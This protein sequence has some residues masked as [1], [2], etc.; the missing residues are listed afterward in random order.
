MIKKDQ[1]AHIANVH[2]ITH[3]L[4]AR[5]LD[6]LTD[7]VHDT[8]KEGKPFLLSGVGKFEASLRKG[9]MGRNPQNGN[10][11]TIPEA[12]VVKFKAS[13]SIKDVLN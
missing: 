3:G 13:Q 2:G 10:P 8:L 6:T 9:R 5:I 12:T 7:M 1:V 4:A 11:V